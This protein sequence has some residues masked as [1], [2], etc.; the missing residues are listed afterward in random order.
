MAFEHQRFEVGAGGIDGG[1]E[2]GAAGAE[3]DGIAN[4]LQT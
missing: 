2:T 4:V 3:D 1:R